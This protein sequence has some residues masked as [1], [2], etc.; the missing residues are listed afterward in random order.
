MQSAM[1]RSSSVMANPLL[2]NRMSLRVAPAAAPSGTATR[3]V[4]TMAR[5]KGVRIIVT[6]ECTEARGEGQTPSRYV[7]QKVCV[8][9][10]R[11]GVVRGG[12]GGGAR[13]V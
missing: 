5:K 4:T 3:C 8:C 1:L 7:T 13:G 11:V 6:L 2:G 12:G 9:F 10:R